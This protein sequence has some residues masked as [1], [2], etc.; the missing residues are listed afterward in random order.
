MIEITTQKTPPTKENIEFL[1]HHYPP[2]PAGNYTLTATQNVSSKGN[3]QKAIVGD[4]EIFVTTQ[5]FTIAGERFKLKPQEI[6]SVFP[7]ESSAGD[8]A[9]V[10]PHVVL[11]RSTMPWE[12]TGQ[13]DDRTVPWLGL[14]LF[15]ATEAPKPQS[16][17]YKQ[18][19]DSAEAKT[20]NYVT[21][22]HEPG[23]ML[24]IHGDE[25]VTVIDVP[26]KLAQSIVPEAPE[27]TLLTHM[28][29]WIEPT[30]EADG[31]EK[32]VC[33]GNRLPGRGRTSIVHLVSFENRY[34]KGSFLM[35][36]QDKDVRFVS[37][38]SWR[39]SCLDEA[40]YKLTAAG[41]IKLESL[42]DGGKL[43]PAQYTALVNADEL[44][45]EIVGKQ[46]FLA[47]VQSALGISESLKPEVE[48][49]LLK[50]G[51]YKKLT[52]KSLL[53]EL[54][55]SQFALP[56][57]PNTGTKP[58][59]VRDSAEKY[60]VRG[61][62]PLRHHL[63][64]GAETFSWYH[65]PLQGG[66]RIT[67]QSQLPVRSADELL[68]YDQSIG[69]L[70]VSYAAAWELGR[71]LTLQNKRVAT[72]LFSW[73]RAHAQHKNEVAT[74]RQQFDHLP[75]KSVHEELAFPPIVAAWFKALAMLKGIPFNYLVPDLRML[76]IES[77]RFFYVD[78]YWVECL[79]DGAFSVG[80]VSTADHKNDA[81]HTAQ[82]GDAELKQVASLST[83]RSG[84]IVR[85]DVV[86]G[87][88]DLQVTG[89]RDAHNHPDHVAQEATLPLVR[90]DNLSS[91]TII[92][93]FDGNLKAADLHQKPEVLHFGVSEPDNIH[94]APYKRLR[95]LKT[96][97]ELETIA[98][99]SGKQVSAVISA[100]FK[101]A[102]QTLLKQRLIDVSKMK[103]DL[104]AALA[105]KTLTSAGFALQM[106]EGVERVR[107]NQMALSDPK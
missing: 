53:L 63:R 96:G 28:R 7:P 10:M 100:D 27:L 43:T 11:S 94:P 87:W 71:L 4:G 86:A 5:T 107:F 90:R 81:A 33:I 85:S 79:L 98:G 56:L 42:E 1:D 95:D 64:S 30:G 25:R 72:A 102:D 66:R 74:L 8:H 103:N 61:F 78:L 70:D 21:L 89:Y 29:Q 54:D 36:L 82:E 37:L 101:P 62:V 6:R 20:V 76:P 18:L 69:M 88:P 99:K 22:D 51:R 77:I 31:V 75:F 60:R 57:A 23:D 17:T 19:F 106:I 49:L 65:G 58:K 13:P 105:L 93:L 9:F 32:A 46:K 104:A 41:I 92:A 67:S 84:F 3:G 59:A 73:K 35:P 83:Q 52:F 68:R 24:D 45:Q 2:A 50:V 34:S 39:F 47:A 26:F 12:R 48:Q 40:S 80:R 15:D 97:K 38:K 14:L 44:K 91:N 16:I 55:R